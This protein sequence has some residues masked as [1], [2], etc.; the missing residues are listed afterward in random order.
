[1]PSFDFKVICDDRMASMGYESIAPA[2]SARKAL[3]SLPSILSCLYASGVYSLS[4]NL[5]RISLRSTR[6]TPS[7]AR[8]GELFI[9]LRIASFSS[10]ESF[11][12]GATEK[13]RE[14]CGSVSISNIKIIA[15][16]NVLKFLRAIS[17]TAVL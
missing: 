13:N 14:N 8:S 15:A 6:N 2:S 5:Q 17:S 7:S 9:I 1:M 11:K 12:S 16:L 10:L 4:V 3:A